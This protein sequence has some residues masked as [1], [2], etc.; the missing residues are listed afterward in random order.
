MFLVGTK[1]EKQTTIKR[2]EC[3]PTWEEDF[4]FDITSLNS[5]VLKLILKSDESFIDARFS[6]LLIQVS[7]LP[8]GQIVDH[9]YHMRNVEFRIGTGE[10]WETKE[11][12]RRRLRDPQDPGRLHLGLQ[13]TL[14]GGIPWQVAPFVVFQVTVTVVE[15]K[16]LPKMDIIGTCDPYCLVSLVG[17]RLV[18]KTK[19]CKRNYTPVWDETVT[20]LLTNPNTDVLRILL[21]DEDLA[22]DDSVGTLDLPLAGLVDQPPV[23]QWA[24]LVGAR[25][26]NRPGQLHYRIAVGPAPPPEQRDGAPGSTTQS[27][28]GRLCAAESA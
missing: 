9:W 4:V 7:W 1:I 26:V 14:K 8:P 3:D 25:F 22:I 11:T 19:V 16:D 10:N 18:Y 21:E 20:F 23:D 6:K 5:D 17:S 24:P 28:P 12:R 27:K 15:A 2:G 13:L